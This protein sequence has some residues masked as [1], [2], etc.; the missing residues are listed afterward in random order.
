VLTC[1][2]FPK[3]AAKFF[4]TRGEG[5]K[6]LGKDPAA[7]PAAAPAK[8]APAENGK[9]PV[10]TTIVYDVTCNGKTHKVTVAPVQ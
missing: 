6:N 2:M 4:T 5:P 1:A 10:R 7:Q 3:V 9:G 8:A